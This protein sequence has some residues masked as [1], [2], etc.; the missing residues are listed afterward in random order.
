MHAITGR[1][2][3]GAFARRWAPYQEGTTGRLR[4]YAEMAAFI[5]RRKL[6]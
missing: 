6:A 4:A 3:F 1:A 2:T 5:A